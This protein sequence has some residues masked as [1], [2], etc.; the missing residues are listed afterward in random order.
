M[1]CV[2]AVTAGVLMIGGVH[3][4]I[5]GPGKYHPVNGAQTPVELLD[6]GLLSECCYYTIMAFLWS[7]NLKRRLV[8][9]VPEQFSHFQILWDRPDHNS[10]TENN[11]IF[12]V[13]WLRNCCKTPYSGLQYLVGKDS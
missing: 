3:E 10:L 12:R 9:E 4:V 2:L 8:K 5:S 13:L 1:E 7:Y 6:F 11:C